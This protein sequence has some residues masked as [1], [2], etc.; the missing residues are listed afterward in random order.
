MKVERQEIRRR[1]AGRFALADPVEQRLAPAR[2]QVDQ[3]TPSLLVRAF[4]GR[5]IPQIA[6]DELTEKLLQHIPAQSNCKS[7]RSGPKIAR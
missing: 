6:A 1:V 5:F 3:L 4:A 7:R 2:R